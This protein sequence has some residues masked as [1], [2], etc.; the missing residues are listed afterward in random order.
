MVVPWPVGGHAKR[1]VLSVAWEAVRR[2]SLA[3]AALGDGASGG[4]R[5]LEHPG[6]RRGRAGHDHD[7]LAGLGLELQLY[8]ALA[9]LDLLLQHHQTVEH[10]L[11]P[12]GAAGDVDIDRDDLVDA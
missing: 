3:A 11:G 8:L 2:R 1:V 7:G 12:W 4:T 5:L 9:P 10:L 6:T